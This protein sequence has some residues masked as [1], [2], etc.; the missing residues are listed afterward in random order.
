MRRLQTMGRGTGKTMLTRWLAEV[1]V[2]RGFVEKL[3]FEM[4][5]EGG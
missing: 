2:R 5:R 1:R 4:D 3:A